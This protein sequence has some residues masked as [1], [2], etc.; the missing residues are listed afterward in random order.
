MDRTCIAGFRQRRGSKEYTD[1]LP[2]RSTHRNSEFDKDKCEIILSNLLI[3]AL[4][5]SPQDTEITITSEL[6]P[7]EN[8]VRISI[9]D[10]GWD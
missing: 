6:L 5:H 2:A 7:E 4:K 1:S 9:I 3:N 10:Q 8:R